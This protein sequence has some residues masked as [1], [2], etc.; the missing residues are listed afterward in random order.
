MKFTIE[1]NYITH[2]KLDCFFKIPITLKEVVGIFV[3]N[4]H[5]VIFTYITYMV[6]IIHLSLQGF[7][8]N[9]N[10]QSKIKE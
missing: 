2:L 6:K 3:T 7:R 8:F 4:I 5:Q 9:L 10:Q 1:I